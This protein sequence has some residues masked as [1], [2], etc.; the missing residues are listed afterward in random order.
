MSF[1]QD[2]SLPGSMTIFIQMWLSSKKV[3]SSMYKHGS[4]HQHHKGSQILSFLGSTEPDE[5]YKQQ[6]FCYDKWLKEI[7]QQKSV[8]A[9]NLQK[10]QKLKGCSHLPE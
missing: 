6:K 3:I 9:G 7:S 10:F 1:S 8:D 2:C 5:A 4:H